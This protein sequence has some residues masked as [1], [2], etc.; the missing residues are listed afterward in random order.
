[1]ERHSRDILFNA[2]DDGILSSEEI[3]NA[4]LLFMSITDIDEMLRL[5][6][7]CDLLRAH[8]LEED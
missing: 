4:C 7:W 8:D 3:M 2:F 6:D 1:M 5:N